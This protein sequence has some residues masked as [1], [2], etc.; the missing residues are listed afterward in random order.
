MFEKSL[1]RVL[2]CE[3]AIATFGLLGRKEDKIF[4]KFNS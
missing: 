4:L 2:E 3:I 1:R